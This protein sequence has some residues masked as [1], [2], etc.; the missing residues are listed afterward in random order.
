MEVR[1]IK[2]SR[3]FWFFDIDDTLINTADVS[4]KAS[5]SIR[6][7]FT[8]FGKKKALEVQKNFNDIFTTMLATHQSK[9]RK[10]IKFENLVQEIEVYQKDVR[11]VY[12]RIKRWSRE[13]FIK[14]A[15]DRAS[16]K[17][18]PKIIKKA[19][20]A[21][22]T[23]LTRNVKIYTGT[24]ELIGEIRKHKRPIYL[25]TSSD[26]RLVMQNENFYYNP[27]YS[28]K[29]KERRI[30][31]LK[32]RGLDFDALSVGD[33]EDKPNEEFFQ[34]AIKIAESDFG[35]KIN[36][37]DAVIVGDSFTDDLQTPMKMG[38]GLCVLFEKNRQG[39]MIRDK[40]YIAVNNLP[41]I[42]KFLF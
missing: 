19:A 17:V 4:E 14:I 2:W 18:P 1:K 24:I 30:K 23:E 32:K 15:S 21:Y 36:I 22:W 33:P 3:S 42:T 26:G 31:I 38:F 29:L 16:L 41:D 13:V 27:S 35:S 8:Y 10:N 5:E 20:D 28:G 39:P 6:K 12:G 34:K 7:V 11:K 40:N 25:L 37:K 9:N